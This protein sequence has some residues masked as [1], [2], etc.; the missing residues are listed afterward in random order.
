MTHTE[1]KLV[2]NVATSEI[3]ATDYGLRLTAGDHLPNSR[4]SARQQLQKRGRKHIG[5]PKKNEGGLQ[6]AGTHGMRDDM[7]PRFSLSWCWKKN[8]KGMYVPK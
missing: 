2:K 8:Q 6:D 7:I 4:L 3:V 1:S 5:V